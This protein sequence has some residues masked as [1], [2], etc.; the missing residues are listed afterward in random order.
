VTGIVGIVALL[1]VLGLSLVITRIATVALA[2]TGLSSEAA[3]FQAR[4]AFTGTGF[5]TSEAEQEAR[6]RER[7]TK[8]RQ[9]ENGALEV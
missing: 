1:V 8:Q 5:T 9:D 3:R 2:H 4:S 6:E 7:K